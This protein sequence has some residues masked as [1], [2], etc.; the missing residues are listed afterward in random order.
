MR[1]LSKFVWLMAIAITAAVTL[2][3]CGEKK[4]SPN[5]LEDEK[6]KI[7]ANP[8]RVF[9]NGMPKNMGGFVL[10]KN[11]KGQITSIYNKAEKENIAFEYRSNVLGT[12]AEPNVLMNVNS[13]G[14]KS[15]YKLFL[16]EHGYAKY[17]D[18]IEYEKDG[19]PKV[20]TWTFEYNSDKQLVKAIKTEGGFKTAYTLS[21]DGGNVVKSSTLSQKENKEIDNYEIHY[22]SKKVTSPIANKGCLML[23]DLAF[24]V[25]IDNLQFAYFA[26]ILGKATKH[27]PI[28]NVDVDSDKTSFD[29][30]LNEAGFPINVVIKDIDE[31]QNFNIVW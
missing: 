10:N 12:T 15:I 23:F 28:Y 29:W 4:D 20:K 19:T 14:D 16:N 11:A 13:D 27:L 18:E 25:D 9:V 3:A 6:G 2:T 8:A 21:Y 30:T 1:K 17:C 7:T 31:T 24:G 5:N 26:G 22:T